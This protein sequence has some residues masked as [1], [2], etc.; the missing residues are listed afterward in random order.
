MERATWPNDVF[1]F[2][3]SAEI[4][5]KMLARI[6]EHTGLTPDEKCGGPWLYIGRHETARRLL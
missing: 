3:D 6:P 2:H 5:S 1:A 4:G